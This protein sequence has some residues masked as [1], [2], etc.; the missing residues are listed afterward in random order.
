VVVV[1]VA[2]AVELMP[3]CFVCLK[4]SSFRLSESGELAAA[5]L[6]VQVPDEQHSASL[7]FS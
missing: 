3:V 4:S 5:Q 1:A 2:V 7:Q 6:A